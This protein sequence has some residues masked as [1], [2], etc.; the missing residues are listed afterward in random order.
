MQW[1]HSS[2]NWGVDVNDRVYPVG[3]TAFIRETKPETEIYHNPT[4]GNYLIYALPEYK[5]FIDTREVPYVEVHR[6]MAKAF[7]SPLLTQD[8][9][10]KYKINAALM[11]HHQVV[12]TSKDDFLD[13]VSEYYPPAQWALVNF[14][15]ISMFLVRR[16]TAN[17]LMIQNHEYRYL[18]PHI[19][20]GSVLDKIR[21]SPD[22]VAVFQN[23]AERCVKREPEQWNCVAAL[24]EI[25]K[26]R[27]DVAG[28]EARMVEL[29][30]IGEKRGFTPAIHY[31]MNRLQ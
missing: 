5:V 11:P 17:Q 26:L 3:N 16:T 6:E 27:G 19:P 18:K 13:K 31:E 10:K 14:D 30:Q 21:Q 4:Y 9:F 8:L 23:E 29:L 22:Q 1:I 7:Y 15:L 24:A 2:N 28:K 12:P 25:A 20:P